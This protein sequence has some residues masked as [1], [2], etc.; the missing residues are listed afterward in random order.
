MAIQSKYISVLTSISLFVCRCAFARRELVTDIERERMCGRMMLERRDE[1][2]LMLML[3]LL[4]YIYLF[5]L[6]VLLFLLLLILPGYFALPVYIFCTLS[7]IDIVVV[8]LDHRHVTEFFFRI[9]FYLR[10]LIRHSKLR[11]LF[12]F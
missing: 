5:S 11:L 1:I 4:Q 8:A 12:V 2:V 7:A 6:L 9:I 3:V 10:I